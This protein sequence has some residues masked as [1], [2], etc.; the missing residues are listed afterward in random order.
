MTLCIYTQNTYSYSAKKRARN[1]ISFW[2]G[3]CDANL[4]ILFFV[5]VI[6]CT[7]GR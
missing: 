1:F 3:R 5:S 6:F 7:N 4:E 2:Q